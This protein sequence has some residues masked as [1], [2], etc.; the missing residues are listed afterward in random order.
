MKLILATAS[1]KGYL[2][3]MDKYFQSIQNN[4]NF[5]A[6]YFIFVQDGNDSVS[7]SYPNIKVCNLPISDIQ[8]LNPN[9]CV[10][11]GEFLK[12]KEFSSLVEDDDVIVFTDGDVEIQR[13]MTEQE[14]NA[15][16]SLRDDDVFVGYNASPTDTLKD[17]YDR[18]LP[19]GRKSPVFDID[20]SKVK[21]YNTGILAMNKRTWI[22][23]MDIYV[24]LFPKADEMLL[25]YAKQQWLISFIIG[26]QGFNI[27][28]MGYDLHN[29]T[30]YPPAIG[31]YIDYDRKVYYKGK[32]VLFKHQWITQD[33]MTIAMHTLRNLDIDK[34]SPEELEEI[35]PYFGMNGE[36]L[37]EMPFELSPYFGKGIKFWQYPNQFSKYLKKL[38]TFEINSYLEVGCRW[39]GTFIITS[40]ILKRKNKDFKSIACDL[41]PASD[42]L[43][44]Y[45]SEYNPFTYISGNSLDLN[46]DVI[47]TDID[48]ILIDGDH[49]YN[50]VKKDFENCLQFN[51]K[52]VSFHDIT[53]D[54][55]EGTVR[56][57]NEIKTQYKHH[58]FTDQYDSVNGTYLGIGLIELK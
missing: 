51:P 54:A 13:P 23:L 56:F 6:N 43:Q 11:H 38:S 31:S 47:N 7:L 10:Q 41:L 20:M 33:Y 53:N 52:Y 34:T 21:V 9:K 44:K 17:E 37:S 45:G 40:E 3:R 48:M 30:H 28:E 4:S 50:G 39:G 55:C 2:P 25:H 32:S 29:H 24:K 35:L 18:V 57:W 27:K 26:T 49:S 5:N 1:D 16:G 15:F 42:I 58:E 12:S 22:K 36:N 19:T 46:R 8:A 14:M